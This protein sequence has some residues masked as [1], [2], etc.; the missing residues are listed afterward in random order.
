MVFITGSL[1]LLITAGGLAAPDVDR[2]EFQSRGV[3]LV[4]RIDYPSGDGPFPA[5]VIVHG[6]GEVTRF[7]NRGHADALVAAGIAVLRY[8]KRGVGESG[9]FY[10]GV[11]V[12]N[13]DFMFDLLADDAI[14]GVEVLRSQTNIISNQV[15][16]LGVSQGGWIVPLAATRTENIAFATLIVGP[17]VS[18]GLE[19]FYS[20]LTNENIGTM[21]EERINE[22]SEELATYT[23]PHGFDPRSSLETMTQPGL[24]V[25]GGLDESIPTR[26]TVEILEQVRDEFS[27]DFTIHVY[28]TATH[29]L[30]DAFTGASFPYMTEV[31]V[32]WILETLQ[33]IN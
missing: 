33:E 26:E 11:G 28:P 10:S 17:A 24:W 5:V 27:K 23:G 3:T 21:S 20:H 4:G 31:A 14:A 1:F 7:S 18:I 13:G 30:R 32:P 15:G 12:D 29:G 16:L 25:L 2:V 6:S 19:N 8:D 9:G 22:L